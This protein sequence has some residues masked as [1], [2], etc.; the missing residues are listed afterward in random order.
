[1]RS[2]SHAHVW[3]LAL[4][5][6]VLVSLAATAVAQAA[7]ALVIEKFA[8]VNCSAGHEQCAHEIVSIP[9]GAPFGEQH[10]SIT[11]EPKKPEAEAEGFVTAGGRVPFGVTDFKVGTTGSLPKEI[12]TAVVKHIRTDVAPGLSTSPA[13]VPMCSNAQFGKEEIPG[14]E[15]FSEP[16]CPEETEIGVNQVTV[17][18]A[19]AK[20]DLALEG[21]AYNLEQPEG[22]ASNY[23]VAIELPKAITGPELEEAFAKEGHPLEKT[24]PG[25]EKFYEEK[26][27]YSHTLI[28]GNVEWGKEAKGT[29]QG[30]YH[31]YFEIK[32]STA[33]PLISS[34]LVFYGTSGDGAF[35]TNATS[36]PGHNTTTL[37]LTDLEGTPVSE[38]YTTPV[39]LIE[40]NDVPF[41]PGFVVTP[42]TTQ[43]DEPDAL[44]TE[45]S[46]AHNPEGID[47]SQVKSATITM[48]EGM[49]LNPSAAYGLEVCTEA[50]ARI[51]S[52]QF[53]VECPQGSKLGTD[54][55]DVPGLP[56]GSLTGSVYLGETH[57]QEPGPITGP[58]YRVYV[59][60]NS[61]RYG[62]SV[63]LEGEATTNETTGQITVVV[64]NPPEQPFDSLVVNFERGALT[65]VANPL[66]CGTPTGSANFAPFSGTPALKEVAF[67]VSITG[68]AASLPF[69]LTQNTEQDTSTAGAHTSYTFNLARADGQ[70]YLQKVKTT[71]PEGLVGAI[72]DVAPCGEPQAAQGSCGSASRIGTAT[73]TAGAGG[74]PF[75]FTGPVYLTG[76]YNGAPYGLSI[77]VNVVAGP[78]NFGTVVTRATITV[79]PTTSRV[80]TESSLPTIVK[81]VPVRLRTLSVD[82][83]RQGFLYNPTNCSQLATESSLTST[84]GTVQEGLSSP[85]QVEGCGGLAFKPTF[86]ASTSGK[87]SKENGASLVTTL[88][89]LPGQAN[90]KSVLV[91]LPKALPSRL[92]TLQKACLAKVFEANPYNCT[93]ESPGS[94]VGTATAVT[95]VLPGVMKGP[96]YLVS[97]GGEAFPSLELVLESNGVR[98]ILEGKT[99][100]KNGITTTNFESTPDVPVSSVTVTLPVGP[101]SALTTEKLNT[102]LCTANLVMATKIVGQ[103]GKEFKQNTV[104]AP[105]GCGVQIVG[106][107]VIGNTAYLTIKTFAAG[108]IS[109]GG[110]GLKT[111]YR[112][113]AGASNAT[114]LKVPLSSKGLSRRRPF[115]VKIRVGFVPKNKG[116]HSSAT[117]TVRFRR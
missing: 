35:I 114:T 3:V 8:A 87:H 108:R 41:K 55:L 113:L 84:F 110:S 103:N 116:A 107:K 95:P 29:G 56:N 61:E 52:E 23:G 4:L 99:N 91:T 13:A 40:C 45:F 90:V 37:T 102:N 31:D 59:V 98:V 62:V 115:S 105:T 64:P 80:T 92:T 57:A 109:G 38:A 85:F 1:M 58:P 60:A 16:T 15:L 18:L 48:P 11:K 117:V 78:F 54:T 36:C 43:S 70:Q 2:R 32:V 46:L 96:A 74:F 69:A 47:D 101:H 50:Q 104:I 53:G 83:N 27:W 22:R 97:H 39:V 49:T 19:P 20:I 24:H 25:A 67:G 79:N 82:V 51:H 9:L 17:Y 86:T 26:Q 106:H 93:K 112:T 12:P 100:I 10:Y 81:G 73:V 63:R 77:P 14:S 88:T 30:D 68:C 94:E 75:T 76:P 66:I 42:S 28:E 71:L 34:R 111:V 21:S 33:L 89:Q 7:E 72:P 44:T 5:A 65:P 6:G